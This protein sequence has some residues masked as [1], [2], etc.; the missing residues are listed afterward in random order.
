MDTL[1]NAGDN[2]AE[3]QVIV[4]NVLRYSKTN[5]KILRIFLNNMSKNTITEELAKN[6][7]NK[8]KEC[9]D[10]YKSGIARSRIDWIYGMNASIYATV[11]SGTLIRAGRIKV[12]IIE[13]IYNRDIEIINFIP[14]SF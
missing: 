14:L 4:D 9:L 3:G 1:I 13:H 11:L 8:S 10:L 2:D 6:R 12:P 5:K 7:D